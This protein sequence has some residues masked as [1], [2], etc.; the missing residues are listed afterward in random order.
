MQS[1]ARLSYPDWNYRNTFL[2]G[3]LPVSFSS[4]DQSY[5]VVNI[6]VAIPTGA[7]FV[8][9]TA[10]VRALSFDDA[11][12]RDIKASLVM[13]SASTSTESPFRINLLCASAAL[14]YV[15]GQSPAPI[16]PPSTPVRVETTTTT[17]TI[18]ARSTVTTTP[19]RTTPTTIA[20]TIATTTTRT[21]MARS[22]APGQP[23]PSRTTTAIDATATTSRATGAN[24]GASNL[25]STTLLIATSEAK[26]QTGN[27]APMVLEDGDST[28]F[29]IIGLLLALLVALLV[30]F[31]AYRYR[32]QQRQQVS[33]DVS[34]QKSR[35]KPL[36][37]TPSAQYDLAP[38]PAQLPSSA[39]MPGQYQ[40]LT[41]ERRNRDQYDSGPE[42]SNQ[43]D[44]TNAPL[45][46]GQYQAVNSKQNHYDSA[47]SR[48]SGAGSAQNNQYDVVGQTYNDKN[49]GNIDI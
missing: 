40:Q 12:Q 4:I 17:T 43:Y 42:M 30:A 47:E 26:A 22:T 23:T 9:E 13:K 36:P 31:A 44:A 37:T 45:D 2:Q 46:S 29:I 15:I 39:Q 24:D 7:N 41:I 18:S 48:L 35:R 8:Q 38:D 49:Y 14:G 21:R 25:S 3:R 32:T 6:P 5:G 20:T 19:A 16:T 34:L 33:N 10:F 28:P 1:V 11:Q 27:A